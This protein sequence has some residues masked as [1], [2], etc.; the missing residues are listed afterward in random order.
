M[1]AASAVTERQRGGGGSSSEGWRR[2]GA[3][4]DGQRGQARARRSCGGAQVQRASQ[5]GGWPSDPSSDG[6]QDAQDIVRCACCAPCTRMNLASVCVSGC[7]EGYML[8]VS[9]LLH[10]VIAVNI[11]VCN[12]LASSCL[13][14]VV[15]FDLCLSALV[16]S[17]FDLCQKF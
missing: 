6:P 5:R 2:C 8:I 11:C 12:C 14:Y 10:T 15:L 13:I 3:R 16:A 1:A 4:S 9:K 17:S 7:K